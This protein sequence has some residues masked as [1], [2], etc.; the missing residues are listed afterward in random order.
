MSTTTEPSTSPADVDLIIH[1]AH[2]DP[3]SV[4]GPHQIMLNGSPARIIRAFL[5]EAKQAWVVDLTRGEPGA[6]VPMDRIHGDGF[7]ELVFPRRTEPFL[8][9]LAVE[10]FEGHTWDF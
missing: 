6:R 8:Y 4:L 3:F 2:W 10:N 1:S 7:Y 9:R 5:P